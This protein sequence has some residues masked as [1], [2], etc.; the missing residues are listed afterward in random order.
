LQTTE[1]GKL[2]EA[3]K[4]KSRILLY[5]KI[6]L[7]SI[8]IIL[9]YY[10]TFIWMEDRWRSASSYYSHGYFVP[11]IVAFLI[12]RE[13]RCFKEM[14]FSYSTLGIVLFSVGAFIQ[15]ASAFMRI[16]FASG[17]SFVLVLLG[18]IFFL[19]GRE[20]GKKLLFPI[21]FLTTMVPIPLAVIAAL[22]LKLKLFAAA[23]AMNIINLVGIP[24]VQD[25]SKIFFS[26]CSIVVAD[27]CSG[28][29]SLIALISFG[30]L[31]AYMSSLLNYTKPIL[32]IASIPAALI[33]NIIRI[34]IICMVANKWGSEIATGF[35][36][37]V[38]GILIFVIA[39]ILLFSL[40]SGLR[41]IDRL[42][43]RGVASRKEKI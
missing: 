18:I 37:D 7:I 41:R 1:N 5:L 26:D 34:L 43:L 15:I 10:Q 12:W 27:I 17:F 35:V 42:L 28:L 2:I 38:T 13:R 24:A 33:A 40:G 4:M 25:G 11:F 29:K 16:Y 32:F 39:F 22:S 21:L 6:A 30:A 19:F 3:K 20:V 8:L 14:T 36:H 23:C 9:T 31:F